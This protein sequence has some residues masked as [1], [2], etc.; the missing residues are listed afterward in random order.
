MALRADASQLWLGYLWWILEP[1]LFVAVFYLVFG[2]LLDNPRADFLSFLIIG[3]LP[4]QWFS[5]GVNSSAN[6]ITGAQHL[7]AQTPVPKSLLVLSRVQQVSYKQAAVFLL[8]MV[9]VIAD[10][11]HPS[12]AWLFLPLVMM[13]QYALVASCALLG[14]VL[15][16]YARDFARLIQFATLAL[17]FGSG[18]FWDV[19]TLSE[20]MQWW[21]YTFNPL[22]FILDAYRQILLDGQGVDVAHVASI[23]IFFTVVAGLTTKWISLNEAALTKRVL[24]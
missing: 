16:C 9:Y 24:S 22:A 21:I 5:G 15:V 1:V 10:G 19:R 18:I 11:A 6:S 13:A 4:F 23:L 17:M 2:V 8:L 3:K 14:A 7:I 20:E 12:S